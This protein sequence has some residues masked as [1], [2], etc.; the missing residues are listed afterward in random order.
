MLKGCWLVCDMDGTLL[1]QPSKAGGRYPPLSESPCK[2]H[3]QKWLELGGSLCACSTAGRRMWKQL[4]EELKG[5]IRTTACP[6]R[7]RLAICGFS[8]AAMYLSN[9]AGEMIEEVAYRQTAVSGGT[10]LSSSEQTMIE[11]LGYDVIHN[12]LK[13]A[14]TD[15]TL[16]PSLSAKY[17]KPYTALL[18]QLRA[19]GEDKFRTEVLTQENMLIHGQYLVETNDALIDLQSVPGIEEKVVVQYTVLGIPMARFEKFFTANVIESLTSQGMYCKKQ[20]NSVVIAR[21]GV[22]KAT[23]VRWMETNGEYFEF[24]L[25]R[26]VAFGDVPATVD[27]PLTI[28]PPMEF[29]SVSNSPKDDPPHVLSIGGEEDGTAIFVEELIK[30]ASAVESIDI[31]FSRS[32]LDTVAAAARKA[33]VARMAKANSTL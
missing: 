13:A 17:H 28:H 27:R 19:V 25:N 26:A 23:C 15:E 11:A 12:F 2:P 9:M 7:G 5:D 18:E 6:N 31:I 4:Y 29:V 8:G 22:D 30:T 14:S 24:S 33:V 10:A 32:H 3:L 16:I 21:Q 1:S 20:P